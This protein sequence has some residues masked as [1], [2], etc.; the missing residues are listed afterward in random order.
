MRMFNPCLPCCEIPRNCK[1]GYYPA[2]GPPDSADMESNF[3]YSLNVPV[4]EPVYNPVTEET[5]PAL[6]DPYDYDILIWTSPGEVCQFFSPLYGYDEFITFL[7]RGKCILLAAEHAACL[8]G[9]GA[10][11][12]QAF[13][14]ALGSTMS[15]SLNLVHVGCQ[16]VANYAALN[17][18]NFDMPA[19]PV[20]G[21]SLVS[22]GSGWS[23]AENIGGQV[24]AGAED[25]H[26]GKVVLMGDNNMLTC[27]GQSYWSILYRNICRNEGIP[28]AVY[29]E[30]DE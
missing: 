8:G 11:R 29:E 28:I 14:T 24:L 27:G 20:G 1:V 19:F 25:C 30:E 9:A 16:I 5:F 2:Y 18:L 26:G 10:A 15:I 21:S 12:T 22:I 6:I 13:L 3:Y 7:E 4:G 23:V 17:N